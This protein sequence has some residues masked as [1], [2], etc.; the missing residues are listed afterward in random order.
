MDNDELKQYPTDSSDS[1]E[2]EKAEKEKVDKKESHEKI[3]KEAQDA[4]K[5]AHEVSS[6][7]RKNFEDDLRFGRL[8][9]QW[10]IRTRTERT[11]QLRPCLTINRLPAFIRQVVNEARQN[12]PEIK[13]LPVD[14]GADVETAKVINGLIKNIQTISRADIA[15]DTAVDYAVSAGFGYMRVGIDYAH[16]DSFDYDIL[17]ERI[18]NPLTVYEDPYAQSAD[19]SD[20]NMAFVTEMKK[21]EEFKKEF[22]DAAPINWETD[23]RNQ[24][25]NLW[26][27]Q[28]SIRLA[29]YWK[30]ELVDDILYQLADG[31]II[32]KRQ[33]EEGDELSQVIAAEGL[34]VV[35]KRP[36]QT[37][38]VT[39]YIMTGVEILEENEWPGKYIPIIPVYGEEINV[40]GKRYYQSLIRQAKDSQRNYNYWRTAATELVALAPKAPFIGPKGFAKGDPNWQT[41]NTVNHAYLE[42]DGQTAPERQPFAGMPAGALQESLNATDDLKAI[43]GIYDPSLGAKSNETSGRAIIA[44]QKEGDTATY[45]FMDNLTRSIR[46]VGAILID[47]IPHVYSKERIVRVLGED[48]TPQMVPINQPVRVDEKGNPLP[49]AKPQMQPSPAA[50]K[51]QEGIERVYDLTVGKYD[52][53]VTAGPSFNTRREEAAYQMTEFLRVLPDA[54][55]VIGDLLAKN[56]DWPGAEEISDRLKEINPVLQKERAAN[57]PPPPPPPEVQKIQAQAQFAQQQAR[58]KAMESKQQSDQEL[59]IAHQKAQIDLAMKEKDLQLKN[60]D[61][62]LKNL[63]IQAQHAKS[64]AEIAKSQISLESAAHSATV[65]NQLNQENNYEN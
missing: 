11:A 4:F 40:D 52:L 22:P 12:R 15:E 17:I 35:N 23:D 24:R 54:G 48:G 53:V 31:R 45:H 8:G 43:M 21:L 34:E 13:V 28:D 37:Y 47:L 39:Q 38:K 62:E 60:K 58:Q 57:Q 59:A 44:R 65:K 41:A 1:D 3:I 26:F 6:D 49:Q 51:E 27:S 10:D 63:E 61:I 18:A 25:D 30:R 29:E 36:C 50:L 14:S 19:G 16:Y 32:T 55:V 64:L 9:E 2:K 20:W 42:Y 5:L 33:L 46:Q 56:L 7:N